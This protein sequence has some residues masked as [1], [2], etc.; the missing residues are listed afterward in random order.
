MREL[1]VVLVDYTTYTLWLQQL[2]TRCVSLDVWT[3]RSCPEYLSEN[4][5]QNPNG[6]R[7]HEVRAKNVTWHRR[8]R[9][10]SSANGSVGTLGERSQGMEG[11]YRLLQALSRILQDSGQRILRR[12]NQL[13]QG[14]GFYPTVCITPSYEELLQTR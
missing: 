7:H 9:L 11:G 10:T 13:G 3:H 12:T 2:E 5:T 1:T 4:E 8:S 14:R 6:T